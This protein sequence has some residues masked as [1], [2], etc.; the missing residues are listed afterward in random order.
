MQY[1]AFSV[2]VI[3]YFSSVKVPLGF[4]RNKIMSKYTSTK[5]TTLSGCRFEFIGST[6]VKIFRLFINYLVIDLVSKRIHSKTIKHITNKSFRLNFKKSPDFDQTNYSVCFLY[7]Y[8]IHFGTTAVQSHS[9]PHPHTD[10]RIQCIN[11]CNSVTKLQKDLH[12]FSLI[13]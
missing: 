1:Q 12:F 4:Q 6:N 3:N 5:I 9:R 11:Q 7:F 8:N 10:C 13:K 2:S